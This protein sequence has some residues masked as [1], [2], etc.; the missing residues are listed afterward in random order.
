MNVVFV[1]AL[2]AFFLIFITGLKYAVH[3]NFTRTRVIMTAFFLFIVCTLSISFWPYGAVTFPY[4]IPAFIIGAC[5]GYL[6]G[7][8]TEQ[9][10]L[11]AN[12]IEYYVE[13]FAHIHSHDIKNLTWWSIVNFYSVMGGLIL[14]NF[15]GFSTVFHNGSEKW[16]IATSVVGALLLGSIVPYLAHLWSVNRDS[17]ANSSARKINN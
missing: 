9:Q 11:R 7:V 4:T 17:I 13:H 5:L 2:L 10:K 3:N 16:A 1:I 8:R 6:I 14:I 15:V 12:G